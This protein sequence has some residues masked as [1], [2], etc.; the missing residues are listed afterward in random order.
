MRKLLSSAIL[1]VVLSFSGSAAA[2][3]QAD[4]DK[5]RQHVP[6]VRA[7][8]DCIANHVSQSTG[9]NSAVASGAI[10]QLIP[11]AV[12]A[13]VQPLIA[14][15]NM[16]DAIY[17]GGG[18]D[19]YKGPYLNDL[20]RALKARL[21]GRIESAK[22]EMARLEE[23]RRV[24]AAR[25]AAERA[26]TEAKAQAAKAERLAIAQKVRDVVR[27]RAMGCIGRQAAPMLVTDEK[28]EV[29]AKA[30]MLFCEG[31]VNALMAATVDLIQLDGELSNEA[32]IRQA[33]RKR[34]EE[35]VTAHIVRAKAE[36]ILQGQ[37]R[38]VR[39]NQSQ[40]PTL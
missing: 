8:T 10:G 36:L 24:E 38:E 7:A 20:E 22:A 19:F 27:D 4:R 33:A 31:E 6:Y 12:D 28:A 30:A 11:P 35:V 32:A 16:H 2:Q 15:V 17:G 13:C 18:M 5:R 23:A 1:L 29:I 21:A 40:A 34:V 3:A 37:Q 9:F 14:M 26:E 25:L 39:P